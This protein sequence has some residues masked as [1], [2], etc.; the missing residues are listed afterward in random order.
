MSDIAYSCDF[1]G[2]LRE[3]LL[4]AVI[5]GYGVVSLARFLESGLS[6]ILTWVCIAETRLSPGLAQY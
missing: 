3:N 5:Q 4:M 1:V 2:F 6:L